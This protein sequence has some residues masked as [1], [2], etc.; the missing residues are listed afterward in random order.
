M[1]KEQFTKGYNDA[2]NGV[3]QK[4]ITP[5][6]KAANVYLIGWAEGN[7][8]LKLKKKLKRPQGLDKSLQNWGY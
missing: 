1:K 8:D 4:D 5:E 7:E 3:K 2:L 6:D